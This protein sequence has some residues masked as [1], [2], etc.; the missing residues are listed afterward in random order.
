LKVIGDATESLGSKYRDVAPASLGDIACLSFNGNKIITTGGGGMIVTD[1]GEW[2][3]KAKYLTT[4]AKDDEVE[5][6]HDDVGYNYRLT[7]IQAALGCAQME[8]LDEYVEAK[9]RIGSRYARELSAIPGAMVMREAPWAWSTFWMS[10]VLFDERECGI[11]S[12]GLMRVLSDHGIQSRP[13]WQPLHCSPAHAGAF[14]GDCSVS[15][16]LNRN[17]LSL[18]CSVGI[19]EEAQSRVIE[20]VSVV[21]SGH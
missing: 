20:V 7:N 9:R 16:R 10:T 21:C 12:R 13:L 11:G 18:P 4:Q 8:V 2:A 1:N 3:R 5:Y 14:A 17:A 6:V 15:E 19:S